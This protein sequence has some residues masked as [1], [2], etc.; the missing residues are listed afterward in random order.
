[1]FE[2]LKHFE[3][4]SDALV[5]TRMTPSLPP[6]VQLCPIRCGPQGGGED[7]RPPHKRSQTQR[8]CDRQSAEAEDPQHPDK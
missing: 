5:K 6:S 8:S 4:Y 7:V 2:T 3:M 1:M